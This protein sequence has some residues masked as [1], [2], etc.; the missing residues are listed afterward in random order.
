MVEGI[1]A[2][3]SMDSVNALSGLYGGGSVREAAAAQRRPGEEAMA[4]L[5]ERFAPPEPSQ[6]PKEPGLGA[7]IDM[8][9]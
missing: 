4:E 8:Y 2:I 3:G 9:A 6:R 1:G 7:R 5:A